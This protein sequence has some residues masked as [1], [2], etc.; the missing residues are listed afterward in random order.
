MSFWIKEEKNGRIA[1]NK[2]AL[3]WIPETTDDEEEEEKNK[4]S[5]LHTLCPSEV[6]TLAINVIHLK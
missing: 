3:Y 4:L 6:E 5:S 2:I 1:G